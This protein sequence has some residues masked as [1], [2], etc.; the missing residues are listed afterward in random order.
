MNNCNDTIGNRIRNLLACSTV[1][2]PSAPPHTSQMILIKGHKIKRP[3]VEDHACGWSLRIIREVYVLELW[4]QLPA[5]Y[6]A[7]SQYSALSKTQICGTLWK[8]DIMIIPI[9]YFH[10]ASHILMI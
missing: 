9:I 8:S 2:Q 5:E 10:S 7:V 4:K 3:P 6:A 1:P